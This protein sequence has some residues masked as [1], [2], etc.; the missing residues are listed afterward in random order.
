MLL[1]WTDI[2]EIAVQLLDAHPDID[3]KNIRFTD[4]HQWIKALPDFD[5][6]PSRGGE[7]ILE[8]V[9]SAWIEEASD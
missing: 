4:L 9:Q 3:P 7:R 6:D 1:K 2:N 5:D 8:A